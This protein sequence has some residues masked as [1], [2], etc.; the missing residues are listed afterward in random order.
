MNS[1]RRTVTFKK[2]GQPFP[3][4]F[5]PCALGPLKKQSGIVTLYFSSKGHP[6]YG[7]FDLFMAR[8]L[9]DTWQNWSKP[10]N[11]GPEIN[12]PQDDDALFIPASA[13]KR[14]RFSCLNLLLASGPP[15]RSSASFFHSDRG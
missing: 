4:S 5:W 10:V 2:H 13:T 3:G 6:G 8:R 15:V 9:D 7:G 14:A 11:L 12:S 1:K